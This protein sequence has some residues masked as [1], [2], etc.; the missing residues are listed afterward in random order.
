MAFWFFFAH[1]SQKVTRKQLDWHQKAIFGKI[2]K[3]KWVTVL[4]SMVF[5]VVTLGA[6]SPSIFL[7]KL[8][9]GRKKETLPAGY[10]V[11]QTALKRIHHQCTQEFLCLVA[12]HCQ[13]IFVIIRPFYRN[14]CI[15][16]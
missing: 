7:D 5:L 13:K 12:Y 4:N 1:C 15:L 6:E 9:R 10:L 16:L 14:F 3:G 11:V 8:G 2:S